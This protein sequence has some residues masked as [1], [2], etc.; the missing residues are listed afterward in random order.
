MT[1]LLQYDPARHRL[2]ADWLVV[3][4]V[5]SLPWS[6]SATS[7][8]MVAAL[9]AM[10]TFVKP[11]TWRASVPS[12]SFYLPTLLVALGVIGMA[13]ADVSWA[14]RWHGVTS[15]FKLLAIP[16]FIAYFRTS[17]AGKRAFATYA[18]SCV[19]LL[20]ASYATA[21]FPHSNL[22]FSN[23]FGVPV[24]N[25]ATQSGEFVTC[26][27]GLLY[28]AYDAFL[29]R[30]WPWLIALAAVMT[31]M[32]VN[33]MFVATGRTA[34]VMVPVLLAL[35]A[36]KKLSARG[37]AI[38]AVAAVAVGAVAWTSSSY[39]RTRVSDVVKEVQTFNPETRRSSSGER[40]EFAKKSLGFIAEA[41]VFGHG[42]GTIH[43]LFTRS[44]GPAGSAEAATTN[45]HNQTL[46]VGIQIGLIGMA[47][48][49]AMWAAHFLLFRGEGLAA[50]VGSIIVVQNFVGSLF[51]SHLFDFLQGWVYVVGVGIAGGMMLRRRSGEPAP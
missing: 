11:D 4:T 27:F 46:A 44:V 19:V 20:L 16:V 42:T 7:I 37:V 33:I 3:A 17:K 36:V 28:L 49:W 21:L 34:L 24:K 22:Q 25:A 48:L 51:N 2:I 26:L 41:P 14:D 29:A 35:F 40:I 15:F 13:W 32:L 1:G 45:P 9:I 23:D 43:T 12:P 31:A 47:A 50:W 30:R 5:A 38:L 10:L 8:L 39:L 18:W 6:T